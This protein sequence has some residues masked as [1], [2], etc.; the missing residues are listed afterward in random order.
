A[1]DR[2]DDWLAWTHDGIYD[3]SPAVERYLAWRVGDELQTG[4]ALGPQL[5]RAERLRA[6][7]Q[8]NLPQES[9]P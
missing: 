8:L 4:A 7:L 3:G 9:A 5:R 1:F 6:A 2:S